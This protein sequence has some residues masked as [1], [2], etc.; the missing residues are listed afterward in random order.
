L[1]WRKVRETDLLISPQGRGREGIAFFRRVLSGDKRE[2]QKCLE[3]RHIKWAGSYQGL[4][5]HLKR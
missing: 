5:E 1:A 3:W 4:K 2:D